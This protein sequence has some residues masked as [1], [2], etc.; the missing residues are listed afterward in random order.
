LAWEGKVSRY[1][2]IVTLVIAGEMVFG[3]PFH[4]ARFFRPTLLEVFFAP[5]AGRILD[6]TPGVGGFMNLFKLLAAIAVLG[7]ILV[8]WLLRLK[9]NK[10][11]A[12]PV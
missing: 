1:L 3:L 11:S 5:I 4:V 6:A 8:A 7:V 10:S 12:E 9:R 2:Y